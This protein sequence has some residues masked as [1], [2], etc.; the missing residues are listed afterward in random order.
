MS[1]GQ[2]HEYAG[3][4][5]RL[6][7][8]NALRVL[9]TAPETEF[10]ALTRA[11]ALALGADSAMI[12]LV[13]SDRQWFKA[14]Q[15]LDVPETPRSSS[16][17][18]YAIR[19]PDETMIVTD[20]ASDPRF[21]DDPLVT[22][23]AGIRFYA[24]APL[25]VDNAALG[26]LC[27]ISAKPRPDGL[28]PQEGEVLRELAIAA[29]RA[30]DARGARLRVE[31]LER[32]RHVIDTRIK[33]ALDA[34]DMTV[35]T[36][37]VSTNEIVNY[38]QHSGPEIVRRESTDDFLQR[39][40]E[41]DR[42][43]LVRAM[44]AAIDKNDTYRCEFRAVEDTDRWYTAIGQAVEDDEEGRPAI[45]TGV[46]FDSTPARR[47]ADMAKAQAQEL[48]HR[49]NN[50]I[51]I[52]DALAGRTARETDARDDFISLFRSRLQALAR[53][54]R[55]LIAGEDEA[56]LAALIEAV[57]MPFRRRDRS[58][59]GVAVPDVSVSASLSQTLTLVLHELTTNAL[60]YGALR[61]PLG[62]IDI[63]GSLEDG[64]L[65]LVWREE[66]GR[67]LRTHDADTGDGSDD[68]AGQEGAVLD[69][70]RFMSSGEGRTI[71]QRMM[72]AQGGQIRFELQESELLVT[73]EV[74]L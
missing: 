40:A 15:N 27:V 36:W 23:P 63:G 30:L 3:E 33:L 17:C 13:D 52:V 12:S 64:R 38:G 43:P 7:V 20:A 65:T 46:R 74:P 61:W 5:E 26:T 9:D 50:L 21:K 58:V 34:A 24:G 56:D 8:L 62:S 67:P 69:H 57:L 11:A 32:T 29:A 54:Q 72:H 31:R 18:T 2:P 47:A 60:K 49:V 55:V 37:N 73:V 71:A 42:A 53:T 6:A 59:I 51:G 28:S 70:T 16:F 68:D 66:S 41:E 10:D 39:I 14:R 22:G 48:R 35:W 4:E 19:S 44:R 45:I 25:I 1:A